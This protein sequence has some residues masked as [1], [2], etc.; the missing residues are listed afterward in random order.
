[1]PICEINGL[2]FCPLAA[3]I[4]KIGL[5]LSIHKKNKQETGRTPS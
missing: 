3:P 2:V 4:L 5:N 1:M